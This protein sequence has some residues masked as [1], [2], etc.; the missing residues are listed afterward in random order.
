MAK[1]RYDEQVSQ[2]S[3][4]MG[5]FAFLS[6]DSD[7]MDEDGEKELARSYVKSWLSTGCTAL[8]M[9]ISL[10]PFCGLP[11]GRF[12][13]L[14]GPSGHGKSYYLYRWLADNMALGGISFIIDIERSLEKRWAGELGLARKEFLRVY[15]KKH[16][17]AKAEPRLTVEKVFMFLAKLCRLVDHGWSLDENG[18]QRPI[19]VGWDSVSG[20]PSER[21]VDL[22]TLKDSEEDDDGN[23]TKKGDK[24]RKN[25]FIGQS[26]S[27]SEG[28]RKMSNVI[29]D[30][31][32]LLIGTS[33]ERTDLQ[34]A[35]TQVSTPGYTP[36]PPTK[37]TGGKAP[38]FYSSL[39]MRLSR[40][41]LLY[42]DE[43]HKATSLVVGQMNEFEIKKNRLGP[44]GAR[45]R[46]PSYYL[47]GIDDQT[48]LFEFLEDRQLLVC[49]GQKASLILPD[50][51]VLPFKK[52][53]WPAHL[54]DPDFFQTV[55]ETTAA[56]IEIQRHRKDDGFSGRINSKRR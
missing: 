8:N 6:G 19:A 5:E 11:Y 36:P 24:I 42:H 16:P 48:S 13:L 38:T 10:N 53:E 51:T 22:M 31:N 26:F 27:L 46:I 47:E 18:R 29:S 12:V 50:S 45:L 28:F 56:W 34:A 20:T 1:T 54:E 39:K 33:Q 25:D 37:D 2:L 32:I 30:R 55:T 52:S 44:E 7:Y 15:T 3:E 4:A 40:T 41:K 14:Y 35:M 21:E 9:M 49:T 43:E 17:R 23:V